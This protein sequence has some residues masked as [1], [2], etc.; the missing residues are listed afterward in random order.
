MTVCAR[1][2]ILHTRKTHSLEFLQPRLCARQGLHCREL[3]RLKHLPWHTIHLMITII[4]LKDHRVKLCKC[5]C[6]RDKHFR[7]K[8]LKLESGGT[9]QLEWKHQRE[10]SYIWFL[11]YLRVSAY[12]V[13]ILDQYLEFIQWLWCRCEFYTPIINI[14]IITL[15]SLWRPGSN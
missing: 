1:C 11:F 3:S 13:W 8:F 4:P 9:R 2:L 14:S 6:L 10:W 15:F 7:S 5:C 12:K